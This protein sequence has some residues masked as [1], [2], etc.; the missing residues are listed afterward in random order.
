MDASI[1]LTDPFP[2]VPAMWIDLNLVCGLPSVSQSSTVF[3]ISFLM[4]LAPSRLNI[5]SLVNKYSTVWS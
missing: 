1:W 4:A 3:V 5:G 2:L